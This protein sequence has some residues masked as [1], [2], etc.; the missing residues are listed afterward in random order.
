MIVVSSRLNL[1]LVSSCIVRHTRQLR[2]VEQEKDRA[3]L[4]SIIRVWK[5]LKALRDFQRFT[6]TPFKLFIR[7]YGFF[8]MRT[9]CLCFVSLNEWRL[10]G[11]GGQR[12]GRAGVWEWHHSR[13]VR[14]ASGGRGRLSEEDEW[15]QKT[16]WGME[17]LEEKTGTTTHGMQLLFLQS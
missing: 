13:G 5:E 11:E 6:N 15:I 2:D 1:F 7:R 14:A 16:T 3:L 10:Q 9:L 4:K 8:H 12:E 17:I